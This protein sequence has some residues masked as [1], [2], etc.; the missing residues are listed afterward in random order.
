VEA[1]DLHAGRSRWYGLK[2]QQESRGMQV[3]AISAEDADAILAKEEGHFADVKSCEI[4]P[5]KLSRSI[6]AFCNTAGGELFVGVAESD[7]ASGR[8]RSWA[9]FSSMEAANGL[10]QA[11]ESLAPLAGIWNGQFLQC[12]DREG[13]VLH[14]VVAKT[15]QI[16]HA[17]NGTPYIRKGAQNLPVD[18]EGGLDVAARNHR[19]S[20]SQTERF[21]ARI[22]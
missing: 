9:G 10:L 12:P 1:A 21:P 18:T 22:S 6:S 13:Y 19:R 2:G 5:A 17:T 4:S 15:R 3:R 8:Q 16:I 20:C 11:L 14:I 7:V